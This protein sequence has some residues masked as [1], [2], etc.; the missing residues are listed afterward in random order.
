MPHHGATSPQRGRNSLL[1]KFYFFSIVELMKERSYLGEFELMILLAVIH[2]GEEVYGV[3]ISRELEKNRGRHVSVG[4]MYAALERLESKGLASSSLGDPTPERG[5]KTKRFFSSHASWTSPDARH[6]PGIGQAMEEIPG[7][8][9]GAYMKRTE[10]PSLAT[11]IL[12]NM[13]LGERKRSVGR[14]SAGRLSLRTSGAL[15]LAPGAGCRGP[16]L[17]QGIRQAP[18]GICLRRLLVDVVSRMAA[19][20]RRHPCLRRSYCDEPTSVNGRMRLGNASI[21]HQGS[22]TTKA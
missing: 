11:W 12:E 4:S 6:P 3:P 13:T 20:H 17:P 7:A 14:R 2:L 21:V 22:S 19:R 10:P 18:H 16:L 1:H 15:V 9:R 8:E 5:G